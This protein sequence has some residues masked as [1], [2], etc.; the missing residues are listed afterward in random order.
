MKD[1]NG[2]LDALAGSKCGLSFGG[3]YNENYY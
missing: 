2:N 3:I 1:F